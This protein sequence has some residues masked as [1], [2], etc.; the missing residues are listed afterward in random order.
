[1]GCD[2]TAAFCRKGEVR[3]VKMLENNLK[4]QEVFKRTG[5]QEKKQI[6]MAVLQLRSMYVL[7][8]VEKDKHLSTKYVWSYFWKNTNQRNA[9]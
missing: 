9:S 1:M 7:Y 5:L 4:Y 8:T 3:P 6:K 2:Y